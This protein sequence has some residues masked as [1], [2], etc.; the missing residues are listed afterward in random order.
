MITGWKLKLQEQKWCS[1]QGKEDMRK[2][3][4]DSSCISLDT[5]KSCCSIEDT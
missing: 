3:E 1:F 5:I 4:V 2:T